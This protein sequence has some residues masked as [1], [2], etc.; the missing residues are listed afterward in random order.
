MKLNLVVVYNTITEESQVAA[1]DSDSRA[2]QATSLRV[3]KVIIPVHYLY[4]RDGYFFSRLVTINNTNVENAIIN[5]I[6]F[7][8]G[9][10]CFNPFLG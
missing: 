5:S 6:V 10:I 2:R 3:K 4:D 8:I 1:C 9:I 7:S